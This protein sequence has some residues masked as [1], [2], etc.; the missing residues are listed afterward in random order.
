VFVRE[1]RPEQRPRWCEAARFDR[2]A[3]ARAMLRQE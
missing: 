3:L 2:A 1:D